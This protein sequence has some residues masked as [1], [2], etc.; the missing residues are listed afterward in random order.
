VN[1]HQSDPVFRIANSHLNAT[2]LRVTGR[3]CK[4]YALPRIQ[5]DNR[6]AR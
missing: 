3:H 4:F 1:G 2:A 5:P 6:C